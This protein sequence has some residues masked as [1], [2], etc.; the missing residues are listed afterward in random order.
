MVEARR[1]PC[2]NPAQPRAAGS[3]RWVVGRGMVVSE[4]VTVRCMPGVA[5]WGCGRQAGIVVAMVVVV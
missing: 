3:G 1:W 2:P 4:A 5:R